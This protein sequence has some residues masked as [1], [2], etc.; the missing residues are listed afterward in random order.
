MTA[1]RVYEINQGDA[2]DIDMV[3]GEEQFFS[4]SK[5]LLDYIK[6]KVLTQKKVDDVWVPVR[7]YQQELQQVLIDNIRDEEGEQTRVEE[8]RSAS[9]RALSKKEKV[10][11]S[12][13]KK[14]RTIAET[15]QYRE[16]ELDRELQQGLEQD[17][18]LE[19][20]QEEHLQMQRE[21]NKYTTRARQIW[22]KRMEEEMW[23]DEEFQVEK[24]KQRKTPR[25][26]KVIL[27][28]NPKPDDHPPNFDDK[29]GNN[30]LSG[31]Q[32][33]EEKLLAA[34]E[35]S[36]KEYRDNTEQAFIQ[37]AI[38]EYKSVPEFLEE[39]GFSNMEEYLNA[40]TGTSLPPGPSRPLPYANP[41]ASKQQDLQSYLKTLKKAYREGAKARAR[42]LSITLEQY[43]TYRTNMSPDAYT[44]FSVRQTNVT[45]DNIPHRITNQTNRAE[46]AIARAKWSTLCDLVIEAND[47]ES[48]TKA[49]SG[50]LKTH[51][52]ADG[53]SFAVI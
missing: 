36:K 32:E 22:R 38:A 16:E 9:F 30:D 48:Q 41:T 13:P 3:P 51:T 29:S 2:M 47:F 53:K 1:Q 44:D 31:R 8:E 15:V 52:T 21:W 10:L 11:E 40:V 33:E 34:I 19:L 23:Q 26:P 37:N 25:K 39:H 35:K 17:P 4:G 14:L 6:G 24:D 42:L 5:N 45:E 7:E 18:A 20:G 43:T 50:L 28:H 46:E 49:A 27:H 12:R